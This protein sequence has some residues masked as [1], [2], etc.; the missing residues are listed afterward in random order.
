MPIPVYLKV[1]PGTGSNRK[2]D[3][4]DS[5]VVHFNGS[6]YQFNQI[7]STTDDLSPM[8]LFESSHAFVFIGPTGSGKT[9][10]VYSLLSSLSFDGE[11]SA[12][13]IT[14]NKN[15]IDLLQGKQ[16]KTSPAT[17]TK[18]QFSPEALQT[19]FSQ[20]STDKTL[21]NSSS[22][23]SCLVVSLF[24]NNQ[25]VKFFDM[26][27]NEKFEENQS[28][29]FANVNNSSITSKLINGTGSNNLI[30]NLI[31]NGDHDIKIVIH[32]DPYG[33]S[34]LIKSTLNNI[35]NLVK[36]FRVPPSTTTTTSF[37]NNV[38][39]YARP[40]TSSSV[41]TSPAKS[42]TKSFK[43]IV[44]S[45]RNVTIRNRTMVQKLKAPV[46]G[47]TKPTI[48][49]ITK[50]RPPILSTSNLSRPL[51]TIKTA[52]LNVLARNG[53]SKPTVTRMETYSTLKKLVEDLKV[54]NAQLKAD[55]EK[56]VDGQRDVIGQNDQLKDDINEFSKHLSEAQS[57]VD[58]LLETKANLDE[59]CSINQLKLHSLE[60]EIET[61]KSELSETSN[62]LASREN[63]YVTTVQ[64]IEQLK[65]C[66][67][68]LKEEKAK[69]Q[70]T[71]ET[72]ERE[73]NT[74]NETLS[75][76]QKQCLELEQKQ[77]KSLDEVTKL[78]QEI[79]R[80][81]KEYDSAVEKSDN[82]AKE[83]ETLTEIVSKM[84]AENT[85]L[86][87]Q[88]KNLEDQNKNLV[89]KLECI[90]KEKD[91]LLQESTTNEDM[92]LTLLTV[93]KL[94]TENK[95]LHHKIDQILAEKTE[96]D[97]TLKQT[98][99]V[100]DKLNEQIEQLSNSNLNIS[101]ANDDLSQKV[102]SVTKENTR[103]LSKL[104]EFE[105]RSDNFSKAMECNTEANKRVEELELKN[106]KLVTELEQTNSLLVTKDQQVDQLREELREIE[107]KSNATIE[108]LER[109]EM[110]NS[111]KINELNQSLEEKKNQINRLNKKMVK[112][113]SFPVLSN[114][115]HFDAND[116]FQDNAD[117]EEDKENEN[118]I[119][120][121][122]ANNSSTLNFSTHGLIKSSNKS[123]PSK[124]SPSKSSPL[125][126]SPTKVLT[127]KNENYKSIVNSMSKVKLMKRKSS[128]SKLSKHK[129]AKTIK[130]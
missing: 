112:E 36:N 37:F 3:I 129:L 2:V 115:I 1:K 34:L 66:I 22:S 25:C 15:Y 20:R 33:D 84:M 109:V 27:G 95:Q 68:Q 8:I 17:M 63:E 10:T 73:K 85:D 13:E 77:S 87:Q 54:Q 89:Q 74:L 119:G 6:K 105:D 96:M 69:I 16:P 86:S 130:N 47:V 12:F 75:V 128:S 82:L 123:S 98:Q 99:S 122:N 53:P 71:Y 126:S 118:E 81:K 64:N 41:R 48:R 23:R 94:E 100:T 49:K 21:A 31:F 104:Q 50:A 80:L 40:T 88:M 26:M 9:T 114:N 101:K 72:L 65:D 57:K 79:S 38:P 44:S 103:L 5:S 7:L 124:S 52:T 19:V 93:E 24:Q 120:N 46:N 35:A 39:S 43:P 116:I 92:A 97:S 62:T 70:A 106:E 56:L 83:M 108:R 110:E 55:N 32:I 121:A 113:T 59:E 42:P 91:Q 18:T 61:L 11:I 125:K 127:P 51:R 78:N 60:K 76:A 30:T 67:S 28:N 45:R 111:T 102:S 58:I 29:V 14:N 117:S 90:T 107:T 4:S